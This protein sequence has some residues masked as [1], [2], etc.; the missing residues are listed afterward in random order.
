MLLRHDAFHRLCRARDLL[1]DAEESPLSIEAV[2]A[3]VGVSPFHFIRQFEAVFGATPHQ[4]RIQM[5]LE[6]AKRL[7]A[8][9]DRTVTDVCMEIGFSS[10]GSFSLLFRRRVGATPSDYRRRVRRLV[11]VPGIIPAVVIP[12]CLSLMTCLPE[13]AFRNFREA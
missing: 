3:A 9:G 5:K 12:G 7:L 13:S 1:A 2:A 11:Q 6:R 4:Y 8:A 10:L